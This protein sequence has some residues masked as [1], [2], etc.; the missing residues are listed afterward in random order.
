MGFTAHLIFTTRTPGL[1]GFARKIS[2][3]K[4]FALLCALCVSAVSR[5]YSTLN[6]TARTPGSQGFAGNSFLNLLNTLFEELL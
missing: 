3:T 5:I 4:L 6:F 1:Q 2:H